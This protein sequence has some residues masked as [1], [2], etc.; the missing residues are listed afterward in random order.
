MLIISETMLHCTD[1]KVW[2][3]GRKKRHDFFENYC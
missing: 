1:K 2:Q 3:D